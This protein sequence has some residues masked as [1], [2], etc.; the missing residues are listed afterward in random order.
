MVIIGRRYKLITA[1]SERV[2]IMPE[3]VLYIGFI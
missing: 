1:E 2:I 3:D